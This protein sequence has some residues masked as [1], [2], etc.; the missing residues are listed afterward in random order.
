M[1]RTPVVLALALLVLALGCGGPTEPKDFEFGR[2][3]VFVKDTDG[4]PVNGVPVRLERRSGGVEDAGGLTGSV[5]LPGYYFF[6]QTGSNNF[7]VVIT[8][9]SGY[10]VTAGQSAAVDV[11]FQNEET[12]I[13]NFVLRK[14]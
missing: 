7:R 13:V 3:D 2:A 8:V 5:G 6:L 14:I 9:P 11:S 10:E 1:A 4:Q 12:R